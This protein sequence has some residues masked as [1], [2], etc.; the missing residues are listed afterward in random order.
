[1]NGMNKIIIL[2]LDGVLITTPH[3]KPDRMHK[4]GYSDFNADSVEKLNRILEFTGYKIVLSSTRRKRVDK[5]RMNEYFKARGIIQEIVAYVPDYDVEGE[6]SLTRREE[7]ERFISEHKP[8]EYFI[9]DDDKSLFGAS[10]DIKSRWIQ[11]DP[12]KGL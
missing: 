4:D 10:E 8:E 5:D 1:M 12:M 9:L 7:L 6:R 2:D 11:V 3:W